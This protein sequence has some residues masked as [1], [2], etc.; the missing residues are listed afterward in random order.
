M[1]CFSFY[2]AECQVAQSLPLALNDPSKLEYPPCLHLKTPTGS[3]FL[4]L[5][6]ALATES[7]F[8]GVIKDTEKGQTP[9]TQGTAKSE[10]GALGLAALHLGVG[11]EKG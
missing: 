9:T 8:F 10:S 2:L 11:P 6:L 3:A 5:L 1:V 7:I 4:S